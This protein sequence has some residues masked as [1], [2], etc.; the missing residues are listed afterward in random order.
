MKFFVFTCLLLIILTH[1]ANLRLLPVGC[2]SDS[3]C[4]SGKLCNTTSGACVECLSTS[5]C[6]GGLKCAA[7]L[8]VCGKECAYH[9]N[10]HSL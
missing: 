3:D 10:C 4:P 9:G 2:A 1:S 5:D 7:P 8:G 6:T